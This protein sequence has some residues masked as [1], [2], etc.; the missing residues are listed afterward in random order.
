MRLQVVAREI[1]CRLDAESVFDAIYGASENAFWL[2]TSTDDGFSYLGDASGPLARIVRYDAGHGANFLDWLRADLQRLDVQVPDLPFD[3]ALGWV[4]ALGYECKAETDGQ[5]AHRAATPDAWMLFVDRALAF[6]HERRTWCALAL[7][8][9][10]DDRAAHVWIDDVT[11]R[12]H[13]ARGLLPP[14]RPDTTSVGPLRLRHD[15]RAYTDRIRAS[16]D[17]I[18]AGESYEICLTNMLEADGSLD[19]WPAYRFLRHANPVPFAA[20][21]RCGDFS[22][23]S[24]SPER[25]LRIDRDGWAESKPIKGTRR[26]GRTEVEDVALRCE[27][28]ADAKERAEN[29][30]IVDLVRNDLGRCAEVGTVRV[31]RPFDVETYSSVHQLVTTVRARLRADADVTDCVRAV[32]PAGSMT[33][34]PKVRTMEIIDEFEAGARGIYSGS[35]GYFSLSGTVDLNV[36][37][38]TLVVFPDRLTYGVGGAITALSDAD[39]EFE[40]T[41]VKAT[42]LLSLLGQRFPERDYVQSPRPSM[43]PS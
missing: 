38:R 20:Y 17:E 34:A 3:F 2:D 7:A 21:L 10:D 30:M 11:T 37:I 16:L 33:G 26:R 32:F 28:A 13:N 31:E 1:D 9:I 18:H 22:V 24:C 15:R 40:E 35:I 41:A 12:L 8:P 23:L 14:E 5:R 29:L 6:D 27:L 4:G 25:M 36:V 19:P 42:P 43:T 39:A